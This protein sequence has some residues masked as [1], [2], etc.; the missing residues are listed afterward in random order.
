VLYRSAT[1]ASIISARILTMIGKIMMDARLKISIPG[2]DFSD[3]IEKPKHANKHDNFVI[4]EKKTGVLY[5]VKISCFFL[6]F[7]S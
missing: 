3:P 5:S 2:M 4:P 7:K 6:I 1:L